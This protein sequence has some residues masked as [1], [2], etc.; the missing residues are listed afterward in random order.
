MVAVGNRLKN[1]IL[2]SQACTLTQIDGDL[3]NIFLGP[4]DLNIGWVEPELI[5][6]LFKK[7]VT[8]TCFISS[9]FQGARYSPINNH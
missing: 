1:Q 5:E 4:P 8:C 2:L 7:Q 3:D 9:I 6:E